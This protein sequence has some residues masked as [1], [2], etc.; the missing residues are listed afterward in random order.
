MSNNRGR[1]TKNYVDIGRPNEVVGAG[2]L[3][4]RTGSYHDIVDSYEK[5]TEVVEKGLINSQTL[6]ENFPGAL[7]QQYQNSVNQDWRTG[8][9]VE[10][11]IDPGVGTNRAYLLN[12]IKLHVPMTFTTMAGAAPRNTEA[13]CNMFPLRV[14]RKIQIFS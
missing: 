8:E 2:S 9:S 11:V 6:T 13:A 14:F 7:P 10:F 4:N 3:L 1:F 12:N 5:M